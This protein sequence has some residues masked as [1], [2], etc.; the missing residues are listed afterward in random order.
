MTVF[1]NNA[2]FDAEVVAVQVPFAIQPCVWN[3]RRVHIMFIDAPVTGELYL[4]RSQ[5]DNTPLLTIWDLYD[6]DE[7]LRGYLFQTAAGRVSASANHLLVQSKGLI[8]Q[9][10][11]DDALAEGS[12]SRRHVNE[13]FS[14]FTYDIGATLLARKGSAFMSR[15]LDKEQK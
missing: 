10:S 13:H 14:V 6:V 3:E 2:P 4:S 15:V 9:F 11:V 12:V 5:M 7:N 1:R 8:S